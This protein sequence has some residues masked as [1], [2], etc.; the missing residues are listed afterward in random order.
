M[1]D[2]VKPSE[3]RLGLTSSHSIYMETFQHFICCP[4]AD[5]QSS[6]ALGER[7]VESTPA[8][9]GVNKHSESSKP[10][11]CLK[12]EDSQHIVIKPEQLR[13]SQGYSGL[14]FC[15]IYDNVH[16][17][18]LK[19]WVFSMTWASSLIYYL[20]LSWFLQER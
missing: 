16:I 1:F 5:T 8:P 13:T 18:T 11:V 9:Q 7:A 10:Q 19:A 14:S 17:R 12:P 3:D 4:L 15:T 2:S 20:F 6:R